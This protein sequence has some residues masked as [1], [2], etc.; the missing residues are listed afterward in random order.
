MSLVIER[1][2]VF[3]REG[4]LEYVRNFVSTNIRTHFS[5]A[6]KNLA[7]EMCRKDPNQNVRYLGAMI[8]CESDFPLNWSDVN[9]L[10]DVLVKDPSDIVQYRIALSLYRRKHRTPIVLQ[11]M[12][13]AFKHPEVR[14]LVFA[15]INAR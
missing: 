5:T 11:K 7:L 3:A 4:N 8:L 14:P 15:A 1:L 10:E 9:D 6:D 13:L 12:A 2:I